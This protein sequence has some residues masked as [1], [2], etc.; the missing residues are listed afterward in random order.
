MINIYQLIQNV[1]Y[2]VCFI[3]SLLYALCWLVFG[4]IT[5]FCLLPE[6]IQNFNDYGKEKWL[7]LIYA[8]VFFIFALF[9]SHHS[10]SFYCHMRL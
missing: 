1:S 5:F 2:D 8:I 3:T 10:G 7:F 9:Y 6:A 4:S